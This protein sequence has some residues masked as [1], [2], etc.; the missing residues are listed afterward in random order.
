M[1]AAA[2][3]PRTCLLRNALREARD[4]RLPIGR[5]RRRPARRRRAA[6]GPAEIPDLLPARSAR[7][8]AA[9]PLRRRRAGAGAAGAAIAARPCRAGQRHPAGAGAAG[10]NSRTSASSWSARPRAGGSPTEIAAARRAGDRQRAQRSAGELRAARRDPVQC[11]ADARGRDQ[12][13]DRHDQRR[14]DAAGAARRPNMPAI[15]SRSAACPGIPGLSWS[16]AFAAISSAPA[17]ALGLG[18]EIGSLRA[19]PARRRGDL[20]RRPARACDRGRRGLDRRR[21]AGSRATARPGSATATA[22]RRRARCPTLTI[23]GE[24]DLSVSRWRPPPSSARISLLSH[25]LRPALVARLGERG[26]TGLYSLVAVRHLGLDDPRLSPAERS[27]ARSGSRRFGGGRS[28]P[29]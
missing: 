8:R 7:R 16:E 2:A 29:R 23:R 12:R 18:G 21:A 28:H 27:A 5:A 1:P 15:W 25:P 26:F 14:R 17:E 13:R 11:R 19:R 22:S 24:S 9:D 6:R 3:P 4:L 10:A 20:G